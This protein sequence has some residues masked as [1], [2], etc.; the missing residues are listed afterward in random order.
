V[1]VFINPSP[2]GVSVQVRDTGIGIAPQELDQVFER[3]YRGDNAAA[4]HADGLGLG[5][6]VAKAIVEAHNGEITVDSQLDGGTT[7]TVILPT[8]HK[9]RVAA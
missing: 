5:L 7:I 9:L 8:A 2:R 6:P 4:Q 1:T 3:F